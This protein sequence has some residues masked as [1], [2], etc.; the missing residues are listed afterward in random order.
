MPNKPQE[1]PASVKSLI[2]RADTGDLD[3]MFE[4][5]RRDYQCE[6]S[7][8]NYFEARR[9]WLLAASKGHV[10]SMFNL[11]V[12]YAQGHGFGQDYHKARQWWQRAAELGHALARYN[13][14]VLDAPG[15]AVMQCGFDTE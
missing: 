15:P 9:W 6:G 2:A 7:G 11:G 1:K 14:S 4:L 5:G 10:R 8:A 13:L 12:L 3:A